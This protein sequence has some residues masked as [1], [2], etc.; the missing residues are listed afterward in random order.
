MFRPA[1]MK[2][3]KLLLPLEQEDRFLEEVGRLGILQVKTAGK[4]PLEYD[5]DGKI[6]EERDN[7]L[8][9]VR[10]CDTVLNRLPKE[11]LISQLISKGGEAPIPLTRESEIY[12]NA[13]K[14]LNDAEDRLNKWEKLKELR[15]STRKQL[16]SKIS[17]LLRDNLIVIKRLK[18]T[19]YLVVLEGWVRNRDVDRLVKALSDAVKDKCLISL[20]ESGLDK[21]I[22]SMRLA[23]LAL[24]YPVLE[25]ALDTYGVAR[26]TG[27]EGGEELNIK[28]VEE[29]ID[30][31]RVKREVSLLR[32]VLSTRLEFLKAKENIARSKSSAY[33]EGWVKEKDAV[34]LS[35]LLE[36]GGYSYKLS[37]EAPEPGEEAP[38]A[39]DNQRFIRSFEI[40]TLM[41]GTPG[42]RQIDP[43]PFLAITYTI[44]FG[45]MFADVFDGLLLLAF[46]L[47]LYRGFGSRS[48]NGRRLSEILIAISLSS[49][50]F[51]FLSGEF[52]GGV[53][54]I[55]VL[56]FN[57][58]EDPM[59]FLQLAVVIGIIQITTGF[60]LGFVNE[61]LSR[62][63]KNALGE[64]LSW[65]I[66]IYGSIMVLLNFYYSSGEFFLYL[67]SILVASGLIL[68]IITS[69]R[70][71]IEIMRIISNIVSYT[72]IV[73]ISIS[74]TGISRAFALLATPLIYSGNIIIGLLTGGAILF[75]TH[76]FIVF[77]ESFIAF[78]HSLRLHFVEFFSKFFEPRGNVF[79]PLYVDPR[80]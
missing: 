17:F 74:H 75:I 7:L 45:L 30:T 20:E 18:R 59:Y 52:M 60:I 48:E 51:G 77:I 65:L 55:P 24:H 13:Q 21:N 11:G 27:M 53:V 10:R 25:T 69:P 16:S 34:K 33:L 68:I 64:K 50:F 57:G 31:G 72:R 37:V 46:S 19:D 40:I 71:L 8:S 28:D 29:V 44:F 58:F 76:V 39:L 14:I 62:R 54:K 22:L 79:K 66:L 42:Y 43:T 9:L 4:K 61:L 12:E 26:L 38:V 78:A 56:W 1:R 49:I 47:L 23:T 3:V 41:F 70:N 73:A 36:K 6:V 2:K 15:L 35:S 63:I 32:K 80:I 67:G 5:Y